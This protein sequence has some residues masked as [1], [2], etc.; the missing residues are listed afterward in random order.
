[1]SAASVI[2]EVRRRHDE[3]SGQEA[4]G[5]EAIEHL[6]AEWAPEQIAARMPAALV[7][8]VLGERPARS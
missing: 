2:A 5:M 8:D 3:L 4:R 7:I 1:M 6:R